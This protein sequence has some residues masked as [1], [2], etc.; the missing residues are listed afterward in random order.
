[1]CLRPQ[2]TTEAGDLVPLGDPATTTSRRFLLSGF[3]FEDLRTLTFMGHQDHSASVCTQMSLPSAAMSLRG[4]ESLSKGSS[5]SQ[6]HR[7]RQSSRDHREKLIPFLTGSV[8]LG[9]NFLGLNLMP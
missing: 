3:S 2:K 1:M 9:W 4:Q 7:Q 6:T 8:A 5:T